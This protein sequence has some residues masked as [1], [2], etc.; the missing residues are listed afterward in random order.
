MYMGGALTWKASKLKLVADSSAEAETAV[1]SKAAKAVVAVRAVLDELNTPVTG[2]TAMIGDNQAAR[3]TIVKPGCTARTRHY[4][5]AVM[6]IKHLYSRDVIQPYLVPTRQ[7]AAD[8]FTKALDGPS[9]YVFREYVMNLRTSTT[10]Y[11]QLQG[12][13][14]RLWRKALGI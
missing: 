13:S 8:I 6:L 4:E 2:A 7:M 9:F 14:S 1:G 11:A 5:R 12:Q 10:A 3:D